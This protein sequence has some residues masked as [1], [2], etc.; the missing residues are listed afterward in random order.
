MRK[1]ILIGITLIIIASAV[2]YIINSRTGIDGEWE[3]PIEIVGLSGNNP[4]FLTMTF[5]EDGSGN[6]MIDC[7][8]SC[9]EFTYEIDDGEIKINYENGCFKT[10]CFILEENKLTLI[11]TTDNEEYTFTKKQTMP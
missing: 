8:Y 6:E 11:S 9:K 3:T 7:D 10:Y 4:S 1:T 5:N 2:M